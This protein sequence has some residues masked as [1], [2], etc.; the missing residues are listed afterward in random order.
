MHFETKLFKAHLEQKGNRNM[1]INNKNLQVSKNVNDRKEE[2]TMTTNENVNIKSIG[3]VTSLKNNIRR[4]ISEFGFK[5]DGLNDINLGRMFATTFK[6]ILRYNITSKSWYYYNG[7]VWYPDR[8]DMKA[9]SLAK[10]FV[11]EI[12]RYCEEELELSDESYKKIKALT[13]MSKRNTIVNDAR[14]E[15]TVKK[16]DFDTDIYLL[17]LQNGTMDLRTF[18]FRPH[19]ADDM[20]SKIC[21]ASYEPNARCELWEKSINEIMED[22]KDKIDYLQR[23]LGYCLTGDVREEEFYILYGKTSRNGKSTIT[24]TISHLL[25]G[26]DGYAINIA[27]GTL[28]G[29]RERSSTSPNG[30][31][32]RL[33][34]ARLAVTNELPENMLFNSEM[35]KTLTGRDKIT[36]RQIYEKEIEF[37]PQF[38]LIINTNHLPNITDDIVFE[39]NRVHV[40]EL[41]RHF[42]DEEQDKTLKPTLKQEENLTGILNW[43]LD[44]LKKCNG[45]DMTPPQTVIDATVRFRKDCDKIGCFISECLE[46]SGKNM[47]MKDLYDA[48]KKWAT[49]NGFAYEGKRKFKAVLEKKNLLQ[50]TGTINGNTYSNVIVGYTLKS[51]YQSDNT[52]SEPIHRPSRVES[53]DPTD[54]F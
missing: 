10:V 16:E 35:I 54:V 29:K 3:D 23:V 1:F 15:Y 53:Q 33:A 4:V 50:K 8:E 19:N 47:T 6:D 48:Y 20:L 51:E 7:K 30:D 9:K 12:L 38:K 45:N 25:G 31:I 11:D 40:I 18:E 14:C 46:N 32:A 5:D 41:N 13:S 42:T 26:N 21:N 43:L 2:K 17:N 49:D 39:S 36:A 52:Y 44:G 24:D 37:I 27:E 22:D 34:G 28:S